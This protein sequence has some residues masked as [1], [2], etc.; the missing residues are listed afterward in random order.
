MMY[1][2]STGACSFSS[3]L[4]VISFTYQLP[5]CRYKFWNK[6]V[7]FL[8]FYLTLDTLKTNRRIVV[9]PPNVLTTL[10]MCLQT[11]SLILIYIYRNK[12]QLIGVNNKN[13]LSKFNNYQKILYQSEAKSSW[14]RVSIKTSFAFAKKYVVTR[15]STLYSSGYG[16]TRQLMQQ[17]VGYQMHNSLLTLI[18]P[19]Y[20]QIDLEIDQYASTLI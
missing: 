3:I 5:K 4:H 1:T 9:R 10:Q 17:T 11:D 14:R 12:I 7:I 6:H 2:H 18:F 15:L 19:C 16:Y 13:S 8:I 20:P